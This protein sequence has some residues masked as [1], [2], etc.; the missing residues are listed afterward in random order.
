M[1][2]NHIPS[3]LEV[4]I[5]P[6]TRRHVGGNGAFILRVNSEHVA[7]ARKA[8]ADRHARDSGFRVEAA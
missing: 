4:E 8:V 6:F 1:M 5:D 7:L 3:P 2:Q